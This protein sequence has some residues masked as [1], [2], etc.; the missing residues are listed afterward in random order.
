MSGAPRTLRSTALAVERAVTRAAVAL[1]C[2]ALVL[3]ISVGAW[4]VIARFVLFRSAS[5]SE[6]LIQASLIW[7][8]YLALSG[9]M[10]SGTLISVDVLLKAS[11]GRARIV[12]RLAGLVAI[13]ALLAVLLWFGTILCWRIRFQN[14]AGLNIS[15]A[16]VYAALPV[17]S[18]LSML[19]LAAHAADPPPDASDPLA[20]NV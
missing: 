5:W 6:P 14:I 2:L 20:T 19:A 15:A 11:R 4:Q 10:R 12:L 8:T 18:I 13:F 7:M 17:G 16:W 3:A 9:A 1:G